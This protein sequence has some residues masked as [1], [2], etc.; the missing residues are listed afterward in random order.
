M[1]G[2]VGGSQGEQAYISQTPME[3]TAS[4]PQAVGEAGALSRLPSGPHNQTEDQH[5]DTFQQKRHPA[6]T[7]WHFPHRH[8]P[9][10]SQEL[11]RKGKNRDLTVSKARGSSLQEAAQQIREEAKEAQPETICPGQ[12]Q[13]DP[14]PFPEAPTLNTEPFSEAKGETVGM[15]LS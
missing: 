9:Y 13:T 3:T 10:V 4:S 6:K 2:S 5:S 12:M 7:G 15:E 8:E 1:T 11:R 14:A